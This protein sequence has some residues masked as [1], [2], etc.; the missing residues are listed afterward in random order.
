MLIIE[1]ACKAGAKLQACCKTLEIS[2]RTI[3][4]W[5]NDPNHIDKRMERKIAPHNK[6]T[7]E[8]EREIL[9][10]VNEPQYADATPAKIVPMLADRGTYI[11][12]ES[13]MYRLLRRENQLKHRSAASPKAVQ[14]PKPVVAK[15]TN[16]VFSWDITYLM[17][18]TKGKYFYLYLF[19]DIYSRKIVGYQV[20]EKECSEYASDILEDVCRKE[21]I[22]KEEVI[23]HSDNGSPM[24]GA[25]MLST[26]QKLGVIPSFSRPGVSNDNPYSESLFRTLKYHPT[27]PFKPFESVLEARE[28]VAKCVSWYNN[29]HLHSGIK[30]VTPNQRHL[31]K[32]GKILQKRM[33]VY[34]EA[35]KRNPHRWSRGI[36]NWKKDCEVH[37]NPEKGK[38]SS[39]EFRAAI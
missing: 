29:Q 12:S 36:R 15:K 10:I 28:W 6:L 2:K 35:K 19:M 20:Y 1:E 23:L 5:G 14:R 33:Q 22:K 11:A 3:E 38:S 32:D 34:E 27:Y 17:T 30:F 25:M 37:L 31:G 4:R 8:E 9:Q 16:Q 21:K 18:S 7:A 26:M 24:K 13:T 39:L